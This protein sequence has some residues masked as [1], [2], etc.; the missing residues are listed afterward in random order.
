MHN[1][2]PHAVIVIPQIGLGNLGSIFRMLEDLSLRVEFREKPGSDNYSHL[3]LPGVGS[4]DAGMRK[5]KASGWLESIQ[6]SATRGKNILGLCLGAQMLGNGSEEGEER[7]LG[8]LP[9][10]CKSLDGKAGVP[11]PF[12]GWNFVMSTAKTSTPIMTGERF[13]F[14]HSYYMDA[15]SDLTISKTSINGFSYASAIQTE[16]IMGVQF[17]PEKS[18]RFGRRFFQNYFGVT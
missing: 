8:L 14:A 12:M 3:I 18:H 4:F 10:S 5:L 1:S 16:H 15:S 2:A 11:V 9:F 13:F 7:G 6:D 17:H